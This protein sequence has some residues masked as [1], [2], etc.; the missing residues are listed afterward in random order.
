LSP[1]RGI[2]RRSHHD[3]REFRRLAFSYAGLEYQERRD[4][5]RVDSPAEV[6]ALLGD[7]GKAKAVLGW[8]PTITLD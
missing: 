6:D 7:A 8:E 2:S 4:D 5:A 3:V 1:L